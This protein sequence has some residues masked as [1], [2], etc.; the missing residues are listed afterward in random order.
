M[1]R[2]SR[3]ERSPGRASGRGLAATVGTNGQRVF[4]SAD[5][6]FF[7]RHALEFVRGVAD[8]VTVDARQRAAAQLLR[9]LSRDIDKEEATG[10][11]GS[12]LP[13]FGRTRIR[14]AWVVRHVARVAETRA[15]RQRRGAADRF[16]RRIDD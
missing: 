14:L 2:S 1:V 7:H 16:R 11:R 3:S 10:D 8:G 12:A 15:A 4:D 9:S 13:L 6:N 5:A